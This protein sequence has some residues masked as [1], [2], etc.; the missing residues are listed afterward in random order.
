MSNDLPGKDPV[1]KL[2]HELSHKLSKYAKFN[3]ILARGL[4]GPQYQDNA[5]RF[6]NEI[7]ADIEAL[8][9]DWVKENPSG[10]E[11]N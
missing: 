9:R 3:G 5:R 4:G 7:A 1:T 6:K 2:I 11:H 10:I 8:V